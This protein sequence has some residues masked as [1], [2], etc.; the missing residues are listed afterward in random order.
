MEQEKEIL[1]IRPVIGVLL[2]INVGYPQDRE[3]QSLLAL[4]HQLLSLFII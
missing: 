3:D 1:C 2:I 4:A